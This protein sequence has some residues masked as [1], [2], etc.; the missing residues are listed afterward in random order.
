MVALV[1]AQITC[2]IISLINNVFIVL[3]THH[4]I[5]VGLVPLVVPILNMSLCSWLHI[6]IM[7]KCSQGPG[8]IM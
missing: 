4:N 2:K 8:R 7:N 6:N 1:I 5:K 3:H